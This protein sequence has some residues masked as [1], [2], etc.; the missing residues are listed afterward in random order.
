MNIKLSL[1]IRVIFI[2]FCLGCAH[3]TEKPKKASATS[4]KQQKIVDLSHTF[5]DETIY[6]VTAK[7]FELDTVYKGETEKG[8]YYS[9]NNFTTAEHGGTHIDAPIHFSK[10]GQTVD[11]IPLEKL[12]GKAIKIDVSAKA[13]LDPDYQI[14]IEDFKEWEKRE[15]IKIPEGSIVLLA[16]G[17][18][19]YYPDK[20]KYLG[21]NERGEEALKDLHFPGLAP[22]AA[23]WL[24]KNRTINAIGIDTPSI[25]YGQSQ[26]FKSH[27]V[28]LSQNIPAF[29]NVT[30]LDILPATGFEIIALPMKIKGGSGGPLRIIALVTE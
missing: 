7:E 12:I 1:F 5:S 24:I 27:V 18:S 14:S 30:N 8:Y 15:Q 9:A 29:E 20:L 4:T 28:L 26:F 19:K 25:D 10:T 16:T 23:E 2:L 11:Q 22:E 3:K 17:F 13:L 21:T 6:W